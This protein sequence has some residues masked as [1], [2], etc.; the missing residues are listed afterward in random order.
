MPGANPTMRRG[1]GVPPPPPGR[2]M[3]VPPT[4]RGARSGQDNRGGGT[5]GAGPR[6]AG[7]GDVRELDGGKA[8]CG[9]TESLHA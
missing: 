8:V 4:G 9:G 5:A 6:G 7:A 3:V 2:R 1:P